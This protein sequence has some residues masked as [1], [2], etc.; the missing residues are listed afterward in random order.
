MESRV[1]ASCSSSVSSESSELLSRPAVLAVVV[2]EGGFLF[3]MRE[4]DW[5]GGDGEGEVSEPEDAR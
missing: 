3:G 5:G 4:R 1:A 2:V